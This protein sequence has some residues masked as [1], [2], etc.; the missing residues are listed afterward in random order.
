MNETTGQLDIKRTTTLLE[1]ELCGTKYNYSNQEEIKFKGID[2]YYCL[3]N[4]SNL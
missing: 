1:K 2:Q 3:K 4:K